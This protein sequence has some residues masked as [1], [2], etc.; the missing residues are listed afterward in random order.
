MSCR[1]VMVAVAAAGMGLMASGHGSRG[2]SGAS[3]YAAGAAP[4]ARPHAVSAVNYDTGGRVLSQGNR[5]LKEVALTIDD[6]P[7]GD[8]GER[9]LDILRVHHI[10]ATFFVTG[11]NVKK[12]PNLVRRMLAEGHEV[13]NHTQSH[14]R[15][16][17]LTSRQIRDEI[18]YC[19]IN[20]WRV[21]GRNMRLL[22]PPGMRY[23]ATALGVARDMGYI[24]VGDS[25][26]GADY[27][28]VSSDFIAHRTERWVENGSIILLHDERE[29]TPNALPQII[30]ALKAEGYRFVTITEML[31]HLRKR[32]VVSPPSENQPGVRRK[33]AIEPAPRRQAQAVCGTG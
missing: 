19:D 1:R 32:A 22:R 9:L 30:K 2:Q 14:L 24:V 4:G 25:F 33:T 7:H 11:D 15:L 8:T 26:T 6:G 31:A 12:C 18:A 5:A 21:T 10:R 29:S 16:D 27:L 17:T 28:D 20:F 23:N 13:G 3:A